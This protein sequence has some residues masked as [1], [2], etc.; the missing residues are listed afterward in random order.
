MVLTCASDLRAFQQFPT[1]LTVTVG[2]VNR[3]PSF[4]VKFS[5]KCCSFAMPQGGWACAG[6]LSDIPPYLRLPYWSVTP[7]ITVSPS[8]LPSLCGP[9]IV[10][11]VEGVQLALS[12]SSGAIAEQVGVDLVCVGGGE[13]RVFSADILDHFPQSFFLEV[14]KCPKV[15]CD[16]CTYLRTY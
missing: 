9:F 11:C 2:L 10:C 13:F 5:L 7:I 15:D 1:H 3:F 14:K 8:L 6:C 4:I 16:G 12:V